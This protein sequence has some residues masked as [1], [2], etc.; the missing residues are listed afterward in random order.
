MNAYL[1]NKLTVLYAVLMMMVVYIHSFY[2]EARAYPTALFLQ[3]FIGGQGICR[4]A[5]CLF[6]C[7]SGYL[8]ARNIDTMREALRKW[9]KRFASLIFPYVIWNII[10]VLWYVILENLPG[11][12]QYVNSSGTGEKWL[13]QP[14]GDSFYDLFIAPAAFQLWFLRDLLVMFCLAP[15]LWIL[16]KYQWFGALLLAVGSVAVYPWLL[17]FWLGIIVTA[18]KWN[19][20]HVSHPYGV[21]IGGAVVFLGYCIWASLAETASVPLIEATVNV[22]GVYL[23]WA[24]F[25]GMAQKWPNMLSA[26]KGVWKYVCGYSFFIYCFHEPTINIIKKLVVK[27]GGGRSDVVPFFFDHSMAHGVIGCDRG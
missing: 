27:I 25:D 23:V 3:N 2:L 1:S 26:N 17:Y 16:A 7:L 14:L 10:F 18:Q 21:V 20:E 8:F 22:M 19:I 13:Q 12:S 11:V 4:I 5:N 9:K 24:L 15:V 6:F